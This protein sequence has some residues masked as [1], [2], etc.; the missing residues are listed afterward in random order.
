MST[1]EAQGYA[2]DAL[3]TNAEMKVVIENHRDFMAELPGGSAKTELTISSGAIVPPDGAGG[4]VHTVDTEGNA[5]SDDLTTITT[6]NTPEGRFIM[7]RAENAARVVTL[8]HAAGGSGQM[9]MTD[10][11]DFVLDALDKWVL[12]HLE[13]TD[14]VEVCRSYGV[15]AAAA[16]LNIGVPKLM[17]HQT[18]CPHRNLIG[19]WASNATATWTA[20]ELVLEDASGNQVAIASFNKTA[21]LAASGA[22]GLD[23]GAEASST[24]Y[25]AWAICKADGTQSIILSTS[26]T[27]AG[28]TFPSGYTYA[29]LIGAVRNNGSSNLVDFRQAGALVDIDAT[30]IITAGTQTSDT[31]IN[32]LLETAVPPLARKV[33]GYGRVSDSGSSASALTLKP[34]TGSNIGRKIINNPGGSTSTAGGYFEALMVTPQTLFYQVSAGDSAEAFATGFEF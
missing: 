21:N 14:W 20:D 30:Q 32:T 11:A 3:R 27:I 17:S 8:K 34:V 7:L 1:L 25:N 26:S 4:G 29:G 31:S 6:T 9:S 24:W 28:L 19:A 15:D 12:F 13:S 23:T 33:Q 2:S 10:S 5:A 22:A 16:R 18:L